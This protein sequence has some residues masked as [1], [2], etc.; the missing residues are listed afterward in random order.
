MT[1]LLSLVIYMTVLTA[2]TLLAAS[3]IRAKGWTPKGMAI[4][5]GNRDNLPE[6]DAFA[7]RAD[8]T[9]RNTLE[10]FVLFIA[11][12]LVAHAAGAV[13]PMVATGAQVFFW[14]RVLYVPVYYAG[15]VPVRTIVWTAGMGGLGMMI[16]GLV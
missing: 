4:A 14:A 5:V 12:A 8:R 6:P 13:N 3:L 15:L 10:G 9:A 1:P 11:I 16:A 7:A 2:L